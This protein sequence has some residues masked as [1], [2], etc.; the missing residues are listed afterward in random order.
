MFKQ[1]LIPVDLTHEEQIPGLFKIAQ[2]L[3]GNEKTTVHLLYVD[4]TLMH[5]SSFPCLDEEQLEEHKKIAEAKMA[6]LML[7]MPPNL[8]GISHTRQGIAHDVILGFVGELGIDGIIMAA[9]KPGLR[10]YFIGSNSER[11]VRHADCSVFVV[12]GTDL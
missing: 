1:I 5:Q 10:N 12:R 11:V 2:A 3:A 9:R 8:K 4:E 7:E 6:E